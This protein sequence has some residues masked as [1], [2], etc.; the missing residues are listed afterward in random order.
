ML[1]ALGGFRAAF[2]YVANWYFIRQST[3]YF[4]ANVNSNPVLQFWSLAV[5]EQFYLVWPLL[6]GGLY[7]LTRRMLRWQWWVIRAV[8]VTVGAASMIAALR[9]TETNLARAYYGT[10]TRAYQLLAGAAL[11]LTPELLHLSPR[12]V[13]PARWTAV[14][15][16]AA[17]VALATSAFDWDRSLAVHW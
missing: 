7:L 3:N 6:F 9:L 5:E 8:V 12:W 2:L 17:L 4:A 11:A 14:V 15:A 13:R 16:L 10:D 1:D